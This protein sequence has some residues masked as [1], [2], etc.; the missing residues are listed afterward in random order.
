MTKWHKHTREVPRGER[1]RTEPDRSEEIAALEDEIRRLR[2]REQQLQLN[3]ETIKQAAEEGQAEVKELM[4]VVAEREAEAK[5]QMQM[6]AAAIEQKAQ[7]DIIAVKKPLL[8]MLGD[9]AVQK[10]V[11]AVERHGDDAQQQHF[12]KEELHKHH[13]TPKFDVRAKFDEAAKFAEMYKETNKLEH[14]HL[15][16]LVA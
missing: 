2:M 1:T 8:I 16:D 4:R 3:C 7:Q 5:M 14:L 10:M 6:Q 13:C 9:Y 11:D 12:L 15:C